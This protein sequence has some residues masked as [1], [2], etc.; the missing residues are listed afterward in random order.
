MVIR[1]K[2][3][4]L[5]ACFVLPAMLCTAVL[6]AESRPGVVRIS[7][8]GRDQRLLANPVQLVS[9][10]DDDDTCMPPPPI[11]KPPQMS[12]CSPKAA[13]T[14]PPCENPPPVPG[15]TPT[16]DCGPKADACCERKPQ[17]GC[18]NVKQCRPIYRGHR[19][20]GRG[21]CESRD[22]NARCDIRGCHDDNCH[23]RWKLWRKWFRKDD[24]DDGGCRN[25]MCGKGS[26]GKGYCGNQRCGDGHCHCDNCQCENCPSDCNGHR[27]KWDVLGLFGHHRDDCDPHSGHRCRLLRHYGLGGHGLFGGD[28]YYDRYY[29]N[30]EKCYL[31]RCKDYHFCKDNAWARHLYRKDGIG[32][33]RYHI[34]YPITPQHFD[35]RDGRIYAAQGYGIPMAVPVAPN[36]EHTYNYSW[37]VPASRITPMS[38]PGNRFPAGYNVQGQQVIIQP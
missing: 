19:F 28:C 30:C 23:N 22:D 18:C 24:C 13:P 9:F 10:D 29:T 37:G 4:S 8:D 3:V 21:R 17:D 14:L 20:N 33:G 36:V 27:H 38:Y 11:C 15:D 35:P 1:M 31:Q 32:C 6:R 2:P 12:Q 26:C 16:A 5:F 7:D 25:G 34:A